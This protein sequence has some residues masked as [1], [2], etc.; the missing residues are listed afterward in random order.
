MR[1][2]RIALFV[3][4]GVGVG[5]GVST[6][7]V[8]GWAAGC[9][10]SSNSATGG[11]DADVE[12]AIQSAQ[13]PACTTDADC[14]TGSA[15]TQ[16]GGDAFCA[17]TCPNGN[18]CASD[19]SC[20]PATTVSGQQ[21]SACLPRGDVCGP[22]SGSD[23]GTL[24]PA[25]MCG[26]LV[27]PDVAALCSC[28]PSA[29]H[30]CQM[31]GC[32]G[33][34]WCDTSTTRCNTAPSTCTGGGSDG[35]G[36]GVAY[37]GGVPVV[38]QIGSDGGTA[39]RLFFAVV[40][41]TRPASIDD[42]AGYP[43]AIIT[44]IFTDMAA[45]SPMPPFSVSTGDYMF[46]STTRAESAPQLDL[47]LAARAKYSGV[48]F[49]TMGN[50]E[51][52]G[53]TASNCGAGTANGTTSNYTN[54][55]S[56]Y[57]SLIGKTDVYYE[58]DIAAPDASWTSKFLFVAGNAW[59]PAQA[60]WLDQAMA[61][62]TTYTFIVRHEP[63]ATS[64]A[65]GVGP[66]EAIMAKYPYTLSITGHSHKYSRTSGRKE[67]I[68]GNGG[69]PMTS[70]QN[71]GFALLNQQADGSIQVDMLDYASSLA[72]SSFHFAVKADGTAAP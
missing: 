20:N 15:C 32:Y 22:A 12:A 64:A 54:Y 68:V 41:D 30:T 65:P 71:Y 39:S 27:G 59:T 52:T 60:T 67:I 40:G 50:H 23:A 29:S 11:A 3:G 37:D 26:S 33:G 10:G 28:K 44:K 70:G 25:E 42:T 46:A 38:A 24:P 6:L 69:A 16:F 19:R 56:K 36:S 49:P 31:N 1:M 51:C 5:A 62:P 7:A 57:L 14:A 61:R 63:A 4:A 55:I 66:S 13:C 21:V 53:A 45:L 2:P 43:T 9:G 34:W 58:I 48:A 72:D 18:E 8:F 17:P 35:G 47:Y